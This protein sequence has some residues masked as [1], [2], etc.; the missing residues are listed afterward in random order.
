MKQLLLMLTMLSC[1]QFSFAQNWL[2][3]GNSG[4]N[5]STNFLGT[6]DTQSLVIRVNNLEVIRFKRN[7]KIDL[8]NSGQSVFIGKDAGLSDDLSNNVNV[9]VGYEAGKNN[10]TG[11]FSNALGYH[12]LFFNTTGYSNVATGAEALYKNT[13]GYSNT[14]TGVDALYSNTTGYYNTANGY[15]ALYANTKGNY[16]NS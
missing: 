15:G 9:F 16:N 10:T 2:T 7:G 12:S 4:T 6:T 8:S 13:T 3:T 5:A 1:M 11:S 14:A